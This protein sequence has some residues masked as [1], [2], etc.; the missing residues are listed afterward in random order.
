[1]TTGSISKNVIVSAGRRR[2]PRASPAPSPTTADVSRSSAV[3]APSTAKMSPTGPF[4]GVVG[5]RGP[6]AGRVGR[7]RAMDGRAVH[8]QRQRAVRRP[9]DL[10]HAEEAARP[11]LGRRLEDEGREERART[12]SRPPGTT[13]GRRRV[14]IS[15]PTSSQ[16]IAGLGRQRAGHDAGPRRA[17]RRRRDTAR[18]GPRKPA[19]ERAEVEAAPAGRRA[20][21]STRRDERR[22]RRARRPAG[23]GTPRRPGRLTGATSATNALTR[24]RRRRQDQVELGQVGGSGPVLGQP[25]V[26]GDRDDRRTRPSSMTRSA[27]IGQPPAEP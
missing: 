1:M 2:R 11:E 12:R 5:A 14:R 26:E 9:E 17:A 19:D 20:T 21:R 6:A 7:L 24:A 25:A 15:P 23:S 3:R 16:R 22:A 18:P 27:R 8:Q 13:A 10:G 4:A